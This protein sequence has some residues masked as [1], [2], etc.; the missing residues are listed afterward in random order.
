MQYE[1]ALSFVT[2]QKLADLG[3]APNGLTDVVGG[4]IDPIELNTS[5]KS[6]DV[7]DLHVII[8]Y[9]IPQC[10][11]YVYLQVTIHYPIC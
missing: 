6:P 11:L 7:C 8:K 4:L 5:C 1:L 9:Y 2:L 3:R 10:G